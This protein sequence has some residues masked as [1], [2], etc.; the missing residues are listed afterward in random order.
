MYTRLFYI[1]FMLFYEK[2]ARTPPFH[3]FILFI[4]YH[5]LYIP[6]SFHIFLIKNS[7]YFMKNRLIR[8]QTHIYC[9]VHISN[10][11]KTPYFPRKS[12]NFIEFIEFVVAVNWLLA[13][14]MNY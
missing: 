7:T 2:Q 10:G 1:F 3:K 14:L 12:L 9:N 4:I 8:T 13:F 11:V 5:F 6:A